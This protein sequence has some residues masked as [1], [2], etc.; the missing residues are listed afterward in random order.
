V[1]KLDQHGIDRSFAITPLYKEDYI[2]FTDIDS[3]SAYV[4]NVTNTPIDKGVYFEVPVLGH[5]VNGSFSPGEPLSLELLFVP[6]AER[7]GVL[8]D[9]AIEYKKG[10]ISTD[11]V[12][13]KMYRAKND[14]FN[15]QPYAH[16]AI[17]TRVEFDEF[18]ELLDTPDDYMTSGGKGL[19]V[20][21]TEDGLEFT[22]L[23]VSMSDLKDAD[24]S[25][26]SN[27]DH[28]IFNGMTGNWEPQSVPHDA[29]R[30][31]V[32][33]ANTIDYKKYDIVVYD[34][35]LYLAMKDNRNMP[36]SGSPTDWELLSDNE[37]GGRLWENFKQYL[38]GDVVT[39]SAIVTFNNLKL[40]IVFLCHYKNYLF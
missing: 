37:V 1:A 11:D 18:I 23:V 35:L 14:N 17:W 27:D 29:E 3:E 10:D 39:D 32:E 6:S 8:W 20:N 21:D 33:W 4:F 7:G 9:N 15:K 12:T 22:D 36:P 25:G 30:G 5:T 24:T 19:K 16:P 38:K 34:G 13:Q 31:G 26:A 28:L 2:S 40:F